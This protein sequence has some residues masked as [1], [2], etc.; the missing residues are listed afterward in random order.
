[1]KRNL[2]C[3]R[4]MAL[5]LSLFLLIGATPLTAYAQEDTAA[6]VT[7]EGVDVP[8][9]AGSDDYKTRYTAQL[10][11][12]AT[13]AGTLLANDAA[14]IT[15]D[16]LR[17]GAGLHA[18]LLPYEGQ[19][20]CNAL[21]L[22]LE[23]RS[24]CTEMQIH[25]THS[26]GSADQ[27]IMVR[28]QAQSQSTVYYAYLD[29]VD[30]VKEVSI[31]FNAVSDGMITMYSVSRVSF[32][33]QLTDDEIYGSIS[34]CYYDSSSGSIVIS[35]Q[36]RSESVVDFSGGSIAL[37]RLST[38]Q[39]T[40][41]MID[42]K[43]K[44]LQTL[45]ISNRF[46]FIVP[47]ANF[48][49]RNSRY[50]L[51]LIDAE[52]NRVLMSEPCYPVYQSETRRVDGNAAY[53]G[54]YTSEPAD[55]MQAHAGAVIVDVYLDALMS[56]GGGEY[57]SYAFDEMYF[58]FD[59]T[60]MSALESEISPF[61]QVGRE[62]Y[63][64]ILVRANDAGY[65]LPFTTA[66]PA[67]MIAP[68]YLAVKIDT[69][70]AQR[71]YSAALVYLLEKLSADEKNIAGIIL[72]RGMDNSLQYNYAGMISLQDYLQTVVITTLQTENALRS[73][74]PSAQLYLPV[75]DT[76]YPSYYTSYDLDG[77][78]ATSMLLDG[79]CRMLDDIGLGA[80]SV[81]PLLEMTSAPYDLTQELADA[82]P[83]HVASVIAAHDSSNGFENKPTVEDLVS[84]L[85]EYDSVGDGGAVLW[86][87]PEDCKG[88]ALSLAYI[89]LYYSLQNGYVNTFFTELDAEN[90]AQLSTLIAKID[91]G[92]SMQVTDFALPYFGVESMDAL[93]RVPKQGVN[94]LL[95]TAALTEDTRTIYTGRYL[96]WNFATAI[97][98][99]QWTPGFGC[100]SL[101]ADGGS[102]YGRALLAQMQATERGGEILYRFAEPEDFSVCDALALTLAVTDKQGNLVPAKVTMTLY[103]DDERIEA[104]CT[105]QNGKM[106]TLTLA[107]LPL[108]AA[109]ACHAFSVKVQGLTT[110]K[111]DQLRLYLVNIEGFSRLLD[112]DALESAI[113]EKR[114][115]RTEQEEG[116]SFDI[117]PLLLLTALTILTVAGGFLCLRASRRK[118][119][120]HNNYN[121][122]KMR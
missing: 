104:T 11:E 58:S 17:R 63:L 120:L 26:D 82:G 43:A 52:G 110:S 35:G 86:L 80:F 76:V 90:V 37:Y 51:V 118:K 93:V 7:E 18:E 71:A 79:I 94:T 101:S 4:A 98:T 55:A 45:Q 47:T 9:E 50:A 68:E 99:L 21:Q 66:E 41:T 81:H 83:E 60:Y 2:I 65:G 14:G 73:V 28:L 111:E 85:D 34:D 64:R 117:Y 84:Q 109:T 33:D 112:D 5:F 107:G 62:V 114:E 20:P 49:A 70:D 121:S 10:W 59:R 108:D 119:F 89:Y 3:C 87:P 8:G 100:V 115:Q 103:G 29:G 22:V 74:Y 105:L 24:G 13:D 67:G 38:L 122:D 96:Y 69:L 32:Y 15:L 27:T 30:T 53:K 116:G 54:L 40:G 88:L 91:T 95:Y 106:T 57:E 31:T 23:N 25:V 19:T 97:G 61:L 36:L 56:E 42:G 48:A 102:R 77:V 78:Y 72:G 12:S 6:F 92:S 75:T 113:L 44:P 16:I 46:T 1:M 39:R